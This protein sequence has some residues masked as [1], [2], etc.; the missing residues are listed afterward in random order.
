MTTS[1]F[2]VS[3]HTLKNYFTRFD[4]SGD[5]KIDITELRRAARDNK[6]CSGSELQS[7]F[8]AQQVLE[9]M[10]SSDNFSIQDSFGTT[11]VSGWT[12]DKDTVSLADW[13]Q[14]RALGDLYRKYNEDGVAGNDIQ[15]NPNN[16]N[17]DTM[18][19]AQRTE[20]QNNAN[21]YLPGIRQ[22]WLEAQRNCNEDCN[23][24]GFNFGSGDGG[25][26][27]KLLPLLLILLMSSSQQTQ[28]AP[29]Y[30]PYSGYGAPAYDPYAGMGGFPGGYP[31]YY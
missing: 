14:H 24:S 25:S 20:W 13:S 30:D 17:G 31:V 10:R 26:L 11:R 22:D 23:D 18:T 5:G 9:H 21:A 16:V 8:F 4:A 3:R 19:D 7:R 12:G 27:E 2:A 29:A 28:Q 15:F 1:N 6:N